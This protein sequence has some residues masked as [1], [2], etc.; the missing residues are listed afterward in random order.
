MIST[1][2]IVRNVPRNQ[3]SAFRHWVQQL[4][5][6]HVDEMESYQQEL[7]HS[8]TEYFKKYKFWLKREFKHQLK[9]I[10]GKK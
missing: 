6:E 4:W 5:Y 7:G 3:A 8:S 10:K 1:A 2:N 9:E